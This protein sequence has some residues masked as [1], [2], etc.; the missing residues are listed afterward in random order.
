MGYTN[1]DNDIMNYNISGGAFK[2][3]FLLQSMCYD[4]KV[5]C[6]PSQDYLAKKLNKSVRTIQRYLEEL[7]TEKLIEKKRRGSISNIYT[8]VLKIVSQKAKTMVDSVKEIKKRAEKKDED[9]IHE[10]NR[11]TKESYNKKGSNWDLEGRNYDF[12]NLENMLLG[13]DKY[14]VNKLYK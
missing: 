4:Q 2:L 6:F 12:K 10:L 7:I 5:Q 13:H 14:D 9:N 8:M 11:N 1:I 3:Y